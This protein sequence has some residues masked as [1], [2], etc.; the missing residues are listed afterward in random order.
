M[1]AAVAMKAILVNIGYLLLGAHTML[2]CGNT[3]REQTHQI[4]QPGVLPANAPA[5]IG[6]LKKAYPPG[7]FTT[8]GVGQFIILMS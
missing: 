3:M 6:M 4:N 7:L 2:V 8:L 1:A 5:L